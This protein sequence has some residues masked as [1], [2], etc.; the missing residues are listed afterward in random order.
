MAVEIEKKFLVLSD[1]YRSMAIPVFYR[2]GYLSN[3]KE[4]VVRVRIAGKKAFLTIKGQS[5][6]IERAEFEYEIPVSDATEMLDNL[7]LKPEIEKYRY[8][9]EVNGFVWEVD[10]FLGENRGLVLAEIELPSAETLFVKPDWIG[11]EVSDDRRYY[12]SNLI[13]HPYSQWIL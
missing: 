11:A 9:I 4:R 5:I 2:Q 10:E 7:C 1:D 6:G 13:L 12:N 3:D 8:K